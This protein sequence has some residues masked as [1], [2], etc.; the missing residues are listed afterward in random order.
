MKY[1]LRDYQKQAS[2]SAVDFFKGYNK[3]NGVL[4][5]PTGSGKSLIIADIASKLQGNVL[6]FQPNKEILEQNYAK[7]KSYG[8]EDCSIY[9]ASFNSKKISRITFATI[10]SVISHTEDFK[11]FKFIIVDECHTCNAQGGMYCDFFD[12]AE[13]K[14]LGLTATPYRL[15]ASKISLDENGKYD[16]TIEPENKCILKFITRTRPRIFHDVIYHVS[17]QTLLSRGYLAQ[18][19]YYDLTILNQARLKRNST[20]MDFDDNSL[21]L[22]FE[23]LNFQDYLV[24]VVKR[25]QSPKDGNPRKGILVFTKFL[26][27]SEELCRRIDGCEMVCGSTAKKERERILNDFKR[28]KIPVVANVGVLT[29][30]FD[31]P[32]LDT[33]V[34]ARPTM[35]LA[36]WYQIVGRV[37]RPYPGKTGWIVDLCGNI[38]RFGKIENLYLTEPKPGE[39]MIRGI[40]NK[41]D[42]QITNIY[43]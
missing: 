38:K 34:M 36:M 39:Y 4:V 40:V 20:G 17:I 19:N 22:E 11:M 26:E 29:T 37:I 30:G 12:N 1:E 10:G 31:Y 5:L 32:E 24:S 6:V 28:G 2:S 42:K 15:T 3:R 41:Q 9:S 8:V 18:L 21:Q 35:S 14:I 27:E 43:F 25:L 7:L 33:I 23:Q 13:R 16:P